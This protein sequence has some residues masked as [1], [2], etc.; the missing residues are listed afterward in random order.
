MLI[1]WLFFDSV[2]LSC[3]SLQFDME[4]N[5]YRAFCRHIFVCFLTVPM[6]SY[7]HVLLVGQLTGTWWEA[8]CMSTVH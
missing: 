7:C 8:W 4:F 3:N 6:D 1:C 5:K 2:L